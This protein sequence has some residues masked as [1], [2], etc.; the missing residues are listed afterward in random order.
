MPIFIVLVG[1]MLS[2]AINGPSP[3][4]ATIGAGFALMVIHRV[5][6]FGAFKSHALAS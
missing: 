5:F 2:R 4:F 3:F 6:A 1:S